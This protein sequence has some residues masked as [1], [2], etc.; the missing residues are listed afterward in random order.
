MNDRIVTA[1]RTTAETDVT[2]RLDPDGTGRTEITTGLGFLDH[3]LTA[4]A[5]HA[6]LGPG[7]HLPRRPAGG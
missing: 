7:A 2:L 1:R 4:L 5:R 3:M 6:R